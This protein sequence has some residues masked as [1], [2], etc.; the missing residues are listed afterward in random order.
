M[1]TRMGKCHY[2]FEPSI[3]CPYTYRAVASIQLSSV[4]RTKSKTTFHL[5]HKLLHRQ[6]AH[7]LFHHNASASM[8]WTP[9]VGRTKANYY[10]ISSRIA[11]KSKLITVHCFLARDRMRPSTENTELS[12]SSLS[13]VDAEHTRVTLLTMC[14]H[15]ARG[16]PFKR[17]T[18]QNDLD[19]TASKPTCHM[20]CAYIISE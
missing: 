20:H 6:R 4:L 18:N 10:Y 16:C 19:G 14:T 15:R 11:N 3:L 1:F 5:A 8:K 7:T 12:S 9:W 17:N 2:L 13:Y